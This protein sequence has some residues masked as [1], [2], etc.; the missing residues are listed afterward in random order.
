MAYVPTFED[1]IKKLNERAKTDSKIQEALRKY[2]GRVLVLSVQEDAVYV[3]SVSANGVSFK[4]NPES[5]P[6][7]MYAEMDR[8]RA[9]KLIRKREVSKW[10]VLFG[11]IK[12]RN[13]SLSDIDFVKEILASE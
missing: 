12:Y 11:K 4:V 10:D 8:S 1:A 2:N 5:R 9:D 3:F 6:N 13:I 7:D